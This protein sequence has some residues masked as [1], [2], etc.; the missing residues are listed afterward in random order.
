VAA[1]DAMAEVA[2]HVQDDFDLAEGQLAEV[3]LQDREENL[4]RSEGQGQGSSTDLLRL[5]IAGV[6][7]SDRG[8]GR[9]HSIVD[10]WGHH[11]MAP[12]PEPLWLLLEPGP[13]R[14]ETGFERS[15][16][17][18]LQAPSARSARTIH[19]AVF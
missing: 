8:R 9:G 12:Q 19:Q 11:P 2:P 7:V 16:V 17:V 14:A 3:E 13:G 4:V 18:L 1:V 6:T 10:G 5:R 15:V